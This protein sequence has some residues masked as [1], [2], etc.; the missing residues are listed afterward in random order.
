[1][2]Q[3]VLEAWAPP[4]HRRGRGKWKAAPPPANRRAPVRPGN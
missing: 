3:H 1:V 2:V 4:L